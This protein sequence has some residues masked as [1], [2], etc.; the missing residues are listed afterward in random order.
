M[1]LLK[2][3]FLFL[4]PFVF[5]QVNA[6]FIPGENARLN[7][8]SVY[9]EEKIQPNTDKY[10]IVVALDSLE[11][12]I[13]YNAESVWPVF[14][15][16]NLDW[17]KNYYWRVNALVNNSKLVGKGNQHKFSIMRMSIKN[18]D[19]TFLN[20]ITNKGNS[21][22]Y[23]FFDDTHALYNREG[24]PVWTLPPVNGIEEKDIQVKKTRAFLFTEQGTITF[25]NEPDA[26][27]IDYIG[28]VV[29]KSPLNYIYEGDTVSFHHDLKK[30]P[31]G[32][33][34]VLGNRKKKMLLPPV[35]D[36][37][38][39]KNEAGISFENGKYYKECEMGLVLE[40]DKQGNLLWDWD[41]AKYVTIEDLN[42]KKASNNM[43]L[44]STHLNAF[45]VSEDGKY[46]YAGFRDL[47]RIVMI[48]KKSKKVIN[49]YGEKY[50]SGQAIFAN[51]LFRAQH[52]ATITKRNT[53]LVLNNGDPRAKTASRAIEMGGQPEKNKTDVP[54]IW[55]FAFDFDT[56]S[57][58]KSQRG[59]NITELPNGNFLICAGALN[60]VFEVTKD[61]KV[62]WDCF[63]MQKQ[64]NDIPGPLPQYRTTWIKQLTEC[65]FI[66]DVPL[67]VK[68]LSNSIE[69]PV[70]IYNSGNVDD[71][72]R[73]VVLSDDRQ[74]ITSQKTEI[75]GPGKSV[76]VKMFIP[77]TDMKS[78]NINIVSAKNEDVQRRKV[79]K[80]DK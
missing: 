70:T 17:G 4:L 33:Y 37:L 16:E 52:D 32:N 6:Q 69:I 18:A 19:T 48:E 39:F 15:V 53:I 28:K 7:Y 80:V 40:F 67:S 66:A 61:K 64:K 68:P 30:L 20:I 49:T 10:Q 77:H 55:D 26:F 35:Y 43:P 23:L 25:L 12:K 13:I 24:K 47:S 79:V 42:F 5:K 60:R 29:W 34:M 8:T 22:G 71:S 46:V 2:K 56:L 27:E 65:R 36:T 44:Y 31:S 78:V 3:C 74:K 41:A 73:I 75:I 1:R 72:Y 9:F 38:L 57:N 54:L 63:V 21:G 58:G 11:K 51:N 45:S 62:V 50:P 76:Q 59:G 14:K